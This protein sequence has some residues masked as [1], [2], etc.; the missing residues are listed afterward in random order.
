MIYSGGSYNQ[1]DD[2]TNNN[3]VIL[4]QLNYKGKK[5]ELIGVYRSPLSC[6]MEF[7]EGL[8]VFFLNQS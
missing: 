2:L 7:I 8:T 1:N 5:I 4:V 6:V 3:K